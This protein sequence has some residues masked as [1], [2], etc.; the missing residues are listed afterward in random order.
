MDSEE[1]AENIKGNYFVK[2][3]KPTRKVESFSSDEKFVS[4]LRAISDH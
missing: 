1:S 4:P 2:I 3:V